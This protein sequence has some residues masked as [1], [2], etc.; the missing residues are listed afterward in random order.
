MFGESLVMEQV[1]QC[2]LCTSDYY[3]LKVMLVD[4]PGLF[5]VYKP[6][7]TTKQWEGVGDMWSVRYEPAQLFPSPTIADLTYCHLTK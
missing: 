6:L 4:T 1:R 5:D 7:L 3:F 2:D